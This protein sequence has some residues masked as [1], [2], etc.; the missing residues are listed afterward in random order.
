VGVEG[1]LFARYHGK[2]KDGKMLVP[3]TEDIVVKHAQLSL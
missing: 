1:V 3:L 2:G